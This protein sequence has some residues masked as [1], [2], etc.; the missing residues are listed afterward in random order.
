[1]LE[2]FISEERTEAKGKDRQLH[3]EQRTALKKRKTDQMA[4]SKSS[5]QKLLENI[6]KIPKKSPTSGIDSRAANVQGDTL[7]TEITE[8]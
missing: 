3:E 1:V 7:S 4:R 5:L 6:S 8:Q 2:D